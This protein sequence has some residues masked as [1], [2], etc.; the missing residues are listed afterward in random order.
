MAIYTFVIATF[1]QKLTPNGEPQMQWL[2]SGIF[3]DDKYFPLAV[4]VSIDGNIYL[5]NYYAHCIRQY[6]L[7]YLKKLY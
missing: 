4:A 3:E 5:T 6:K 7:E 2:T 1:F